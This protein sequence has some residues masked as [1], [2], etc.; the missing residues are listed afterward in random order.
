MLIQRDITTLTYTHRQRNRDRK[1]RFTDKPT[2][3]ESKKPRNTP[4]EK[5]IL[6][7]EKKN[8]HI[9]RQLPVK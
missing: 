5:N 7:H 1:K 8:T 3:N 2:S 6:S 4:T 9:I